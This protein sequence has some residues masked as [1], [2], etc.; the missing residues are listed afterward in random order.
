MRHE[1]RWLDACLLTVVLLVAAAPMLRL[2]WAALFRAAGLDLEALADT[3]TSRAA[4]IA[5]WHT[6]EVGVLSAM[7]ATLLG[8]AVAVVLATSD[9]RAK[10]TVALVFVGSLLVAPQV[11]ALAFKTLAGPASPLLGLLGMS[12][13]P[14]AANPMLGKWGIVGVLTLHHAPLAAV[15]IAGGL[16]AIPQSLID[17]AILDGASSSRTLR[18]V[19]LPLIRPH[20]IA[21][22]V[23]TFVAGAGNFGIPALLGIQSG[24]LTLPT[25]I[26]RQLSSFGPSILPDVAGLSVLAGLVAASGIAVAAVM[27]AGEAAK[28]PIEERFRPFW[29]LGRSRI[30]VEAALAAL[31]FGA[32]IV[33]LLSLLA[34]ALVPAMGVPLSSST[35]TLAKFH[36]V[37]A[38]QAVTIRSFRNSLLY[39]ATAALV[40]TILGA[41]LAHIM[42]RRMTRGR[43]TLGFVIQLP[44]AL[45]GIAL[46]IACILLLLR[47]LPLLNVS[48]YGT[49]AI[50]LFAYVARFQAVALEPIR[51]AMTALDRDQEEA[52]AVDG[53]TLGQRLYHI[54]LPA[55]LPSMA[56]AALLVFLMAFNELTVSAL[57]WSAGTETL[58]VALLSLEDAGLAGEAA[59]VAVL[60]V[61]MVAALMLAFDRL[62]R[63]APDGIVPWVTLA[64]HP[65]APSHIKS[66]RPDSPR[67]AVI[68]ASREC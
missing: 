29:K 5:T 40:V 64:G 20:L 30:L 56:A 3:L 66:G 39:A 49:P 17:A 13:T 7:A 2:F 24:Y 47:P 44:Y 46:G 60:T 68:S 26:Y 54:V 61:G 27:R 67:R 55:L 37:L 1:G 36:E 41:L 4:V 59:A 57:L 32:A 21:A 16:R 63:F 31:L 58:G 52:A 42:E 51:A 62:A 10:R 18:A 33:P 14:G 12:P 38:V 34:T 22:A 65:S 19:V 25:L 53:A 6:I 50:I 43:E 23:L 48:L 11:M 8:A 45:P 9:V 35:V 28:L 15:T